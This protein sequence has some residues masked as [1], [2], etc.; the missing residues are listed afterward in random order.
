MREKDSKLV[1]HRISVAG[2]TRTY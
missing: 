2:R 1:N